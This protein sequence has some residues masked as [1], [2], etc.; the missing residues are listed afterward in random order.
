MVEVALGVRG[1]KQGGGQIKKK[2]RQKGQG[3][4]L[5]NYKII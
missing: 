1:A 3:E 4:N 2:K 5:L